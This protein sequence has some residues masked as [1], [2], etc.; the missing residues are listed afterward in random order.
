MTDAGLDLIDPIGG[1]ALDFAPV[2]EGPV[3]GLLALAANGREVWTPSEDG[4]VGMRIADGRLEH[5]VTHPM[6]G[7]YAI[8]VVLSSRGL[9]AVRLAKGGS[10]GP[11]LLYDTVSRAELAVLGRE[12]TS[13][14]GLHCGVDSRIVVNA[15]VYPDLHLQPCRLRNVSADT[16]PHGA[17]GALLKVGPK[18]LEEGRTKMMLSP[19]WDDEHLHE[20]PAPRTSTLIARVRLPDRAVLCREV[21]E[22]PR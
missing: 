17:N 19:H 9:L 18:V 15:S 20:I 14:R 22:I 4:V 12:A 7:D 5:L 8:D 21:L 3:K 2:A 11:L 1:V 6:P 13:Q 10:Y 16:Y